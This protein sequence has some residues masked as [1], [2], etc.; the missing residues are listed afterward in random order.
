MYTY[1]T[2]NPYIV[3]RLSGA[4][5]FNT[6]S[7]WVYPNTCSED[8]TD[9]TSRKRDDVSGMFQIVG[10]DCVGNDQCINFP[11]V[12]ANKHTTVSAF[13]NYL[14]FFAQQSGTVQ[15][16]KEVTTLGTETNGDLTN[17]TG[18]TVEIH[19]GGIQAP[20]EMI[21]LIH[22]VENT[23]G[24][25]S[26]SLFEYGCRYNFHVSMY[27]PTYSRNTLMKERSSRHL[28]V[29]NKLGFDNSKEYSDFV[30]YITKTLGCVDVNEFLLL[31]PQIDVSM[32]GVRDWFRKQ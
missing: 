14:W 21:D 29:I 6:Q 31:L 32:N 2:N 3:E 12:L 1:R 16:G 13:V 30:T 8:S 5:T 9:T 28:A 27:S 23:G 25:F 4:M 17:P 10:F 15:Q 11:F 18:W 20:K 22:V 7:Q 26:K 24:E 19:K